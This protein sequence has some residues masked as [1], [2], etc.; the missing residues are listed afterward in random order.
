MNQGGSSEPPT[1]IRLR[2]ISC[3]AM[4]HAS[5]A[6]RRGWDARQDYR[7]GTRCVHVRLDVDTRRRGH[8]HRRARGGTL[9][10]SHG[11][12]DDAPDSPGNPRPRRRFSGRCG[13]DGSFPS[14][15]SRHERRL[16]RR[17]H[18]I[19]RGFS[20]RGLEHTGDTPARCVAS[21]RA[22][23][24]VYVRAPV[25]EQ[26][27]QLADHEGVGAALGLEAAPTRRFRRLS[28]CKSL[29]RQVVGLL[30]PFDAHA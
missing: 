9:P 21:H 24:R 16:I 4:M 29:L 19:S 10:P 23:G 6:T 18:R 15:S 1:P 13:R 5:G 30:R 7:T 14:P 3:V 17:S 25:L 22:A 28:T 11:C 12:E 26:S 20:A 2:P 8:L 27:S